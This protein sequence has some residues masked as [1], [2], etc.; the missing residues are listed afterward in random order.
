MFGYMAQGRPPVQRVCLSNA[1]LIRTNTLFL[2]VLKLLRL[3][4]G[5]G[6]V[7]GSSGS[8]SSFHLAAAIALAIR[9]ALLAYC[10]SALLGSRS[11][12]RVFIGLITIANQISNF[13]NREILLYYMHE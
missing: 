4:E 1:L 7:V 6:E 13:K 8:P 2:I 10:P 9:L 5:V 12:S 11:L 3:R